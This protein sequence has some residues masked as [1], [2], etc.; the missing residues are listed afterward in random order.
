MK[1]KA[2]IV[3]GLAS[4]EGPW[5]HLEEGKWLVEPSPDFD[6]HIYESTKCYAQPDGEFEIVGP[7]RIRAI[8]VDGYEGEGVFL[9]ARKVA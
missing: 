4:F 2:L 7:T 3:G 6:L 8:V 9:Q 5:V 1:T